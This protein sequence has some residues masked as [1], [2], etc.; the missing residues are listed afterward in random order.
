MSKEF[1]E[2]MER[3]EA[4]AKKMKFLEGSHSE[5]YFKHYSKAKAIEMLAID[6][7]EKITAELK[8]KSSTKP[9]KRAR[10]EKNGQ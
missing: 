8:K 5:L 10:N 4:L 1:F 7:D 2:A 6:L 3:V 9:A